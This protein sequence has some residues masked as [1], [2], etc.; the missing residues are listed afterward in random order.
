MYE[1][2]SAS[3]QGHSGAE[4]QPVLSV[5]RGSEHDSPGSEARARAS[6]TNPR[7]DTPPTRRAATVPSHL[8]EYFRCSPCLC[9]RHL[10]VACPLHLVWFTAADASHVAGIP[11]TL[12]R[13]RG[14]RSRRRALQMELQCRSA[15]TH[16]CTRYRQTTTTRSR[17]HGHCDTG[18]PG[19]TG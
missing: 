4:Q 10:R 6:G 15:S 2:T 11:G 12:S 5:A 8:A 19:R 13:Q 17:D 9:R 18:A 14:R 16:E 1:H 3:P 7:P